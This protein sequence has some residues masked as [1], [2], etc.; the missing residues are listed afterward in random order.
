M[1]RMIVILSLVV[2]LAAVCVPSAF[3][4]GPQ[5]VPPRYTND[6]WTNAALN[7]QYNACLAGQRIQNDWNNVGRDAGFNP[8][9]GQQLQQG[10]NGLQNTYNRGGAFNCTRWASWTDAYGRTT[11]YCAQ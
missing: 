1:K 4:Q 11:V 9:W 3:A 5:C 10:W 2:L 7:A 6:A 8:Q